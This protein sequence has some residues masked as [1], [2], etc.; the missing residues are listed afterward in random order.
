MKVTNDHLFKV[1]CTTYINC[2]L[3]RGREEFAM[4][5]A[6]Q[7]V[8]ILQRDRS[9]LEDKAREIGLDLSGG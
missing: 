2:K 4:E 3:T 8:V 7:A 1:L 5:E 9:L 6:V